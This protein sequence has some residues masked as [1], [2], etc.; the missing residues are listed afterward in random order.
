MISLQRYPSKCMF[1]LDDKGLMQSIQV[2]VTAIYPDVENDKDY[3]CNILKSIDRLKEAIHEAEN[4]IFHVSNYSGKCGEINENEYISHKLNINRKTHIIVESEGNSFSDGFVNYLTSSLK[5][6]KCLIPEIN[7]T[8]AVNNP[9]TIA[10]TGVTLLDV[11]EDEDG[12]FHRLKPL[13]LFLS[14]DERKDDYSPT[15]DTC[16]KATIALGQAFNS[17]EGTILFA[18]KDNPIIKRNETRNMYEVLDEEGNVQFAF[19]LPHYPRHVVEHVSYDEVRL[20]PITIGN[21]IKNHFREM[22]LYAK[23]KTFSLYTLDGLTHSFTLID[24]ENYLEL[25]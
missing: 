4:V 1:L 14:I 3:E 16:K 18:D 12:L 17:L 5:Y 23:V 21:L 10:Y 7:I 8:M 15:C 9:N 22:L 20:T 19:S 11:V 25:L 13:C 24:K 6:D 2:S